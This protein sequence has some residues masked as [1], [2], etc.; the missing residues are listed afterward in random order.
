[1]A[2]MAIDYK[3]GVTN[4]VSN[5][6]TFIPKLLAFLLIVA[7]GFFVAKAIAKILTKV[8]QRVGFDSLVERG[9]VKKALAKS[10]YDAA[11]ILSKVVYYAIML[12][13]LSTAFAVF[14]HNPIGDYLHAVIAYLPLV[15][16]A[17]VIIVIGAAVAAAVKALIQNSLGGLSYGTMLANVA[18]TV[19]IA[20]FAIAALDQLHIAQNV[21]NA[22]LYA[23]L[24]AIVGV[25]VVAVGGGG[26]A[27]MSAR[28][29]NVADKY[30]SEKDNMRE[31][32]RNA[33]SIRQQA[34]QAQNAVKSPS[35][36]PPG[37]RRS[38]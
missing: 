1:M 11:G 28:W 25:V 4:T 6:L 37:A 38:Q 13:V 12:F 3:T 5:V 10:E 15:F 2:I 30:D 22:L 35:S 27:T 9:G 36:T 26:I 18:S 23:T 19:I 7:I 24:A 21:V 16:V 17:I 14:G 20:L 29:Q 32:I 34:K 8:L 31:Q 33:P